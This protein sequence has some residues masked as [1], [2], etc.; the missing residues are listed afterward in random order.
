MLPPMISMPLLIE[1]GDSSSQTPQVAVDV[2]GNATV[3]W[4]RW[5]GSRTAIWANRYD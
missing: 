4:A 2:G 5:D 3:I 1:T